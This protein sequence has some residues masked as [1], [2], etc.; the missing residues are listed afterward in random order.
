MTVYLSP[1]G[2]GQQFFTNQGLVLVG[3]KIYTYLAGT[4]TPAVTYTDA[5]GSVPNANP[6][7]LDSAGRYSQEIWF[8]AGVPM[9][10]VIT[11]S[12]GGPIATEDNLTGVNDPIA[13]NSVS[14]TVLAAPSGSS[15]VGFLQ[16]GTGA[17]ARTEQDKLREWKSITDFLPVGYVLDGS[18][19][20]GV[21]IQNAFNYSGFI[22]SDPSWIFKSSVPITISNKSAFIL[23]GTYIFTGTAGFVYSTTNPSNTLVVKDVTLLAGAV[24]SGAALTA[25]WP[26]VSYAH[27]A[28]CDIS[29]LSI[30]GSDSTTTG[31]NRWTIGISLT[32][33]MNAALERIRTV[34]GITPTAMTNGIILAGTATGINIKDSYIGYVG[35]GILANQSVMVLRLRNVSINW[36]DVCVDLVYTNTTQGSVID[37][38][39]CYFVPVSFGIRAYDTIMLNVVNSMFQKNFTG[40]WVG[41]QLNGNTIETGEAFISRCAFGNNLGTGA[42][43]GVNVLTNAYNII[44]G[45]SFDSGTGTGIALSATATYNKCYGNLNAQANPFFSNVSPTNDLNNNTD[46]QYVQNWSAA[47]IAL[48]NPPDAQNVHGNGF[49]GSYTLYNTGGAINLTN[50]IGGIFHQVLRIKIAGALITFVNGATMD[51]QGAANFTPAIGAILSLQAVPDFAGG[52]IWREIGRRT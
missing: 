45:C 48:T 13:S 10:L 35:T 30:L 50:I 34:G 5:S 15:L 32:N 16:A 14:Y 26:V 51:L 9:K 27:L 42:W 43:I 2:N 38:T 11:D 22:W 29:G 23:Y 19:D 46:I 17:V 40:T 28:T 52:I 44:E 47:D 33:A 39:D 3:G 25:S 21:Q 7:V 6:I 20:Y 1:V 31:L 37:I 12:S 8:P 4:T 36:A 24:V 49:N 41:I 18:V